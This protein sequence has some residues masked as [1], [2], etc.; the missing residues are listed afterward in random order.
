MAK[1]NIVEKAVNNTAQF[2]QNATADELVALADEKFASGIRNGWYARIVNG[3]ADFGYSVRN[4]TLVLLQNPN[5]SKINSMGGWNYNGRAIAKGSK[6]LKIVAPVFD[7]N[8][9]TG[10]KI[11]YAFDET[12]TTA[13]ANGKGVK[14]V[15]CNQEFIEKHFAKVKEIV[16]NSAKGYTFDENAQPF[17]YD[18]TKKLFVD[19]S[20]PPTE[21]IACMIDSIATMKAG[22]KEPEVDENNPHIYK[23]DDTKAS[24][25]MTASAI[26]YLACRQLGIDT[27]LTIP[28]DFAEYTDDEIKK[29]SSNLN[30]A[31]GVA[32][33]IVGAVEYFVLDV[34]NADKLAEAQK[35]DEQESK[36]INVSKQ[37]N[38]QNTMQMQ[39]ENAEEM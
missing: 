30:F 21:V 14:D 8:K 28:S 11:N 13:S 20:L 35:M 23:I 1:E 9:A 12:Q 38:Q 25:Q 24:S 33:S 18:K 22:V 37:N 10:Y 3:I 7:G 36:Q 17:D 26:A 39:N 15:K 6:G 29:L 34:A 27:P 19:N 32:G 16:A 5:A 31:K 4:T 2:M